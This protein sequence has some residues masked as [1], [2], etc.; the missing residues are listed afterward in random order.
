MCAMVDSLFRER[1]V[2]LTPFCSFVNAA[3]GVFLWQTEP[4]SGSTTPR[5]MASSPRRTGPKTSSSI[6]AISLEMGSRVF[7]KVLP[8]P[9]TPVRV[10]RAPRQS[11]L[12]PPARSKSREGPKGP[13]LHPA[14]FRPKEPSRD[15]VNG[16]TDHQAHS[17]GR[18]TARL[19]R[20]EDP[21]TTRSLSND[22]AVRR[23]S[24]RDM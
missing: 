15:Q 2:R 4:S 19:A 13:F 3:G 21:E 16:F 24:H 23:R 8:C 10:T 20:G 17:P 18:A 9:L 7:P 12:R 1:P 5:V 14:L 11:T 6:T 22:P